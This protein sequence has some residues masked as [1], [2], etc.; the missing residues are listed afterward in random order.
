MDTVS[1]RPCEREGCAN[2]L[3]ILGLKATAR[4]CSPSCRREH[5][6]ANGDGDP[7]R[8]WVTGYWRTAKPKAPRKPRSRRGNRHHSLGLDSTAFA[9]AGGQGRPQA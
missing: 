8:K 1:V 7:S 6:R 3:D 5:N 9:V 4:F 2:D